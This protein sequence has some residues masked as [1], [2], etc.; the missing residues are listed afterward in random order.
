LKQQTFDIFNSNLKLGKQMKDKLVSKLVCA[1]VVKE[2]LG[3]LI[4][5]NKAFEMTE[6]LK[7]EKSTKI[8]DILQN[9]VK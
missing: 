9:K 1:N 5:K 2:K 7:R 8:F 4:F 3:L 6:L